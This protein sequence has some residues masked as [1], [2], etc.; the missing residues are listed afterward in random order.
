MAKYSN[1]IEY[2]ISTKLDPSGL[3]KLQTQL[4]DVETTLKKLTN[5]SNIDLGLNKSIE[6][7]RELSNILTKSFNSSLKTLD[8][9]VFKKE[10]SQSSVTAQGLATAF[11][12]AGAQGKLAFT[13]LLGQFGRIDT[14]LK[15][16]SS[17]VD[18]MFNTI[19][20]TVRWGIVSSGFS[21]I[22]TS[23]HQSVD[24][25][26]E[27]DDSLT[28]IMLVTDYSRQQMNEYAKSANEAAKALG[29][30]TVGMTNASLVFAQQGG[31]KIFSWMDI[32]NFYW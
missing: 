15:R 6:Q 23:L 16:T 2:Q 3:T 17:T 7:V 14:S 10:L 21:Q 29:S 18:K 25:V 8:L 32:K 31:C 27:L 1:T 20:N 19:G 5:G 13:D 4:Q 26:K 12:Q 28:Q 22:L 30:T 24:Y 9:S 11:K